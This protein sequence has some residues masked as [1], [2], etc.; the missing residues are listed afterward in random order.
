[1]AF[2]EGGQG[3]ARCARRRVATGEKERRWGVG[4]VTVGGAATLG[5]AAPLHG[6]ASLRR[7]ERR[8]HGVLFAGGMWPPPV[9]GLETLSG[10]GDAG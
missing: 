1:M 2:F 4:Q 5:V 3:A 8:Q 7:L 6:R 9:S 10:A